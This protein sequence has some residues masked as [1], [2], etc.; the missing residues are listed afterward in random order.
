MRVLNQKR[1]PLNSKI[2]EDFVNV[3]YFGLEDLPSVG[4]SHFLR[5]RKLLRCI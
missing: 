1:L 4:P 2:N 3:E 5:L